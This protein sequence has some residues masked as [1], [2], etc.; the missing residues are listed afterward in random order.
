MVVIQA[1]A[2]PQEGLATVVVVSLS[3]VVI[4]HGRP[5]ER[6]GPVDTSGS[7]AGAWYASWWNFAERSD[8]GGSEVILCLDKSS[9]SCQDITY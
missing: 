7:G 3:R 4:S 5:V 9:H 1:G 6:L 8:A 2:F